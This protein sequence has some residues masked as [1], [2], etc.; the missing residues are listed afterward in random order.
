LG[1]FLGTWSI[2]G[3]SMPPYVFMVW[4]LIKHKAI[5]TLNNNNNNNNN[6]NTFVFYT[7]EY[8][9]PYIPISACT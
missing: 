1:L 4:Y 3:T 8:E 7:D 6:N 5:I 9:P 2:L